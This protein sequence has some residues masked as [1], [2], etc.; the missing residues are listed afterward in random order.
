MSFLT[1]FNVSNTFWGNWVS[2][3]NWLEPEINHCSQ[4]KLVQ[5]RY[6]HCRY[7]VLKNEPFSEYCIFISLNFF[8]NLGNYLDVDVCDNREWLLW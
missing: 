7:K 5:V 1:T 4:V 6:T 3:K 2:G 8:L